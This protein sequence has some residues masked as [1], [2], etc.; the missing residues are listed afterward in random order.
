[1]EDF[2]KISG[3]E[4]EAD[5]VD[6]F[7]DNFLRVNADDFA[8]GV[9]EQ[10]ATVAG[11]DGS[12]E[13]DIEVRIDVNDLGLDLLAGGEKCREGLLIAGDVGVGDDDAG[14]GYEKA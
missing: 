10:A 9:Q 5:A 6:I 14:A 2:E 4:G 12:I 7:L 1:L 13:G 3:A 11:I 8:A